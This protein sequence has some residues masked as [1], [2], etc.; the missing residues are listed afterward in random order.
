M[1]KMTVDQ[2]LEEVKTFSRDEQQHI[3]D[4]LDAWLRQERL[5]DQLE[6]MLYDA[7][8]LRDRRAPAAPAVASA[9]LCPVPVRGQPVSA[10]LLE[11]RR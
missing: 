11:E 10:T 6:C 3:R 1:G 8:L 4:T 5:E 2:L 9:R 7:G